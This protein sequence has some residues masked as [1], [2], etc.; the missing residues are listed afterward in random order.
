MAL[1]DENDFLPKSA[2]DRLKAFN[3][4]LKETAKIADD[5]RTTKKAKE[6][7]DQLTKAK[8]KLAYAQTN[9]AKTVALER[10]KTLQANKA[11]KLAAQQV[12]SLSGEYDKLS[13]ELNE[14]RKAYK[15]LAAAGK[16]NSAAAKQQL[17]NVK[18]LD[19]Q[20]KKIDSSVGQNQRSV[21]KY[22]DAIKGISARFLGWTAAIALVTKA[23][24]SGFKAVRDNSKANAEL[25]GILNKTRKE[26]IELRKEQLRLGSSTVFTATQV[27]KAQTEL[28]RLGLSM[29]QIITLTPAILD[30]A[31]AMGVDLAEAAE[32]VA[33]QLN[34]FNLE[35]TEGKR[36]TDVL[37]R[38]TQISA[39]N[40]ERLKTSL[41]VVSP[42][43]DA[44]GASIEETTGILSAAVD[45]NIDASTAAT[46]LR[47]IY[48][49][50]AKQ[51]LTWDEAMTQINTSTDKLSTANELFG[52]RGA[53]VSL[54]IAENTEKIDENTT[55]LEG[56][57]GAAQEFAAAQKD[58]LSGDQLLWTSAWEGFF[59][60]LNEGNSN[61][62]KFIRGTIQA[63]T[64]A[65]SSLT[66]AMEGTNLETVLW[67]ENIINSNLGLEQLGGLANKTA[68]NITKYTNQIDEAADAG[69]R[70]L[71][72]EQKLKDALAARPFI[73]DLI[74]KKIKELNTEVEEETTLIDEN[75]DAQDDNN[76]SKEEGIKALVKLK[77]LTAELPPKFSEFQ[78]G[79]FAITDRLFGKNTIDQDAKDF[80]DKTGET[81][82]K[83][84]ELSEEAR[85]LELEKDKAAKKRKQEIAEESLS[86]TA[87][88]FS[89]F[90]NLRIQQID[91][92]IE[93]NEFARNR[94]LEAAGDSEA[95]KFAINQEFDAKRKELQRK[96]ANTE[97]LNSI[98]QI[99]INTATGITKSIAQLGLPAAIPFVALTAAIGAAQAGAVLA[100]PIPEFDDG[101]EYTPKDYIAGEKNPEFRKSK[102]K[103]SLVDKPTLFKN[104]PGD[105]IVSGK[106]SDSIL[107]TI[108]DITGNNLLTNQSS[109]LSLLNN[110]IRE[111]K[112]KDDL[113]YQIVSSNKE[114]IRTIKNKKEVGV[115]VSNKTHH[116]WE[117]SGNTIINRRDFYYRR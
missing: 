70:N 30:G 12:L 84:G 59:Q 47:N 88:I 102:G 85:E 34:A 45:A 2:V 53:V 94:D 49:E 108:Q 39:F 109:I 23:L 48:I 86:A 71:I 104:S 11:N 38:A 29:E 55:A 83:V 87:E 63:F 97:K 78:M 15:N 114:L 66:R 46:S 113:A 61:F 101:S 32:L 112:K 9:I 98:F 13:K 92:E 6:Q 82:K 65:M 18:R 73:L 41:S 89:N 74:K 76:E 42:A 22:S 60:Q 103:W 56:A 31:I 28:S 36:V 77:A 69:R 51:G 100:A 14:A 33:G 35:A 64:A 40:F 57:A 75:T 96:Q 4:E 67:E 37:V 27:T 106:E 17:A 16:E 20:L 3:T 1:L 91:Q 99:A 117:K 7:T 43:A 80:L 24:T 90:T 111:E 95:A 62:S 116:V 50:L 105:K 21:G 68:D 44:V 93:S 58:N 81:I 8:E 19:T 72:A 5:V 110:D 79:L 52:K 115:S 26:T 107:G 10:E 54:V 25:R